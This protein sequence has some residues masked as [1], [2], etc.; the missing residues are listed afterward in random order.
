MK[1]TWRHWVN[2]L[3]GSTTG[4]YHEF[5]NFRVYWAF[6][7]QQAQELESEGIRVIDPYSV[8]DFNEGVIDKPRTYK[9]T[10]PYAHRY[11]TA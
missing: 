2:K 11:K 7:W 8:R 9:V 3:G 6:R 1:K 5:K 4:R 10:P